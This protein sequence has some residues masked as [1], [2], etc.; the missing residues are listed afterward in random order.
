MEPW[1]ENALKHGYRSNASFPFALGTKNAGVLNLYAPVTG[2]FDEQIINL[3]EELAIDISFALRIIDE[4]NERKSAEDQVRESEG[5]FQAFMNYLPVTAF[6]KDDQSTNLFVNQS[7]VDTFGAQDWIGKSVYAQFPKEAAEKMIKEDQQTI[8]NG[9]RKSIETLQI[10]TGETRIFETYKF[11]IER[12]HKPPLLGGF[13]VDI[14]D[15]KRADDVIRES[16]EKYR[17]IVETAE[18]GIWQTDEKPVPKTTYVNRRMAEMLGY[19]PVEMI[20][21]DLTSFMMAEDIPDFN[22]RREECLQGKSGRY[23]RRLITKNGKIRWMWTS[24]T[25]IFDQNSTFLGA[26]AMYSDITELKT[27]EMEV[28]NRNQELHAAY[29]QL[30]ANEEE[31]RQN[32]DELAKNQK[33]L[34]DSEKQYRNV[35]EDQTEFICRFRPD[36][37]TVFVNDAYCRYFGLNRDEVL[38]HRFRPDIPREDRDRV[39]RFFASLTPDHVVAT[40][41]HRIIMPDGSI[42]WQ[43]W[44]DR[45]IFDSSGTITEYQSVGRDTTEEKAAEEAVRTSLQQLSTLLTGLTAGVILVS[46]DGKIEQVNQALCDI[47]SLPDTPERLSGLTAQDMIGKILHSYVAPEEA[48]ARIRKIAS[49]DKP[50][51]GYESALRNGRTVLIDFIPIIDANGQKRG[52]IWH[53]QDVTKNKQEE[54]ARFENEQRLN[55]IYNTVSDIVFQLAIEPDGQYR[56]TSVNQAFCKTTGLSYENIIGKTVNEIIPEPSLSMV[57]EKY[58]RAIEEKAIVRWEET[59]QYPTGQLIGDISIAPICDKEGICTHLVG[60]VHDITGFKRTEEALRESEE[61]SR[62]LVENVIDIVYQTDL[63]GTI[64]F[65]TPSALLLLGYDTLDDIIGRPITSFWVDPEKRNELLASMKEKGYVNDYEVTILKQD[66]TKLPVSISSHFFNDKTGHIAGVEGIIRDIS[67][68]KRVEEALRES[69]E[70]YRTVFETT[71]SATVL[72]ENDA[73]IDLANS[74][75]ERLS[76]YPRSDIENKMKWTV[77]VVKEDLDRMLAQHRLRRTDRKRALTHYEFRFISRSGEIRDILLTVDAIPGTTK[78]VASLLDI[79]DRRRV[80]KDLIQKNEELNVSFEQIATTE[81]ELRANFDELTRQEQELRKSEAQLNRAEEVGRSGSWEFRLSEN[82]V[83]ASKGARIL[84]GLGKKQWAIDEV[85]KIPLPEYRSLLD[86]ALRDLISGK[87]P[88][89]IEFK[90]QRQSDGAVLDIHS[91]AEY[92]PRQNVVFGVIHDITERKRTEEA[93]IESE[94]LFRGLFTQASQLTGVLD[95]EGRLTRANA[96]AMSLIGLDTEQVV[97]KLFWETPWWSQDPKTQAAMKDA[98]S[99]AGHGEDV[100]FEAIHKDAAGNVHYIDFFLKPVVDTKGNIIALL[101]EGRDITELKLA[102][103]AIHQ[104]NKKLNTLSSITRHDIKNQLTMLRGYLTLLEKKLPDPSLNEY[105]KKAATAAQNISSMVQFTKEYENIG[106]DLPV[107]QDCHTLIDTAVNQANLGQ[108]KVKNDIPSGMEV[109]ADSMIVKVCYNLIENAVR[110]GGKI[111]TI[112]FFEKECNG[113]HIIVCE[114]DGDGVP[115][116]EKDKIFDQGFGKN[117]GLGLFLAR[118]ILDITG[119]KI[120]ETGEQGKGARFEILVPEGKWRRRC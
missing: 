16:E 2:F 34:A 32:Y 6:I 60:S 115:A 17:R 92:D 65:V 85:Q 43:R 28:A 103:A 49:H 36:G 64:T 63:N 41:E 109:F 110:H 29:E 14:T 7:M 108:I 38:G 77:F 76:G 5:R 53:V 59:S 72:I 101:P 39:N 120:S 10:K 83:T 31:L 20:G 24:V 57:L 79:T 116:A 90:I 97:G 104:A 106:F 70:R 13:A 22:F 54:Q 9:Y 8:R 55:S 45:A 88:Y 27:T 26:F 3:L 56:F 74:E 112:R 87:S 89:N 62:T 44:S 4:E 71:G 67:D 81:E 93:L 78:S 95:L 98:V 69:E 75:F 1:R 51:L 40:I 12:E 21:R 33:L 15:R 117:T 19:T 84:Y 105:L 111:T 80:E 86:T 11:R 47:Y 46:E 114:D 94:A 58:R 100:H 119:I 61:K 99:R 96:T 68:R 82:A 48:R 73:T 42:R 50:V 18:E 113:D 37:T 102:D 35:V 107:W 23:E 52:R 30:T 118:E 66:G 91:I 25:P